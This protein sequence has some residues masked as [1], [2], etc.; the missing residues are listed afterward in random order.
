MYHHEED[1]RYRYRP[2][3]YQ[4]TRYHEVS[5]PEREN[6]TERCIVN[7]DV[8]DGDLKVTTLRTKMDVTDDRTV[9]RLPL[10]ALND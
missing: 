10:E 6:T 2:G 7:M 4:V 8:S 1:S 5:L 3:C 9:V